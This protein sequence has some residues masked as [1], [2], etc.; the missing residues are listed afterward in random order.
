M[1]GGRMLAVTRAQMYSGCLLVM[2]ALAVALIVGANRMVLM[3][4]SMCSM[5]GAVAAWVRLL[6]L[7]VLEAR[8]STIRSGAKVLPTTSLHLDLGQ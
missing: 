2:A 7:L 6:L 5:G 1:Q 3:V 4:D 8:W